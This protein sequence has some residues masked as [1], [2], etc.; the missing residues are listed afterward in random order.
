MPLEEPQ[1][2]VHLK[3]GISLSHLPNAER[4]KEKKKTISVSSPSLLSYDFFH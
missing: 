1:T 2:E 3:N 4:K